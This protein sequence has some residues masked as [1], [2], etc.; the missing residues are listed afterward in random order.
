MDEPHGTEILG[1]DYASK[2]TGQLH[3]VNLLS[4][5][6]P[7]FDPNGAFIGGT[8]NAAVGFLFWPK[9]ALT[10]LKMTPEISYN[11]H[12]IVDNESTQ[13]LSIARS[14]GSIRLAAFRINLQHYS[15]EPIAE[16][17]KKLWDVENQPVASR[18]EDQVSVAFNG[19]P[20][21]LD[22]TGSSDFAY[23]ICCIATVD[24]RRGYYGGS[25]NPAEPTLCTGNLECN[26]AA[27]WLEHEKLA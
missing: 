23:A 26:V 18:H 27:M 25:D 1:G 2:A 19:F 20:A 22:F 4:P 10:K 6:P 24:V 7:V 17:D 15:S 16:W 5:V 13:T 21:Q 14:R 12:Y 8:A 3:V 9:D 11:Y